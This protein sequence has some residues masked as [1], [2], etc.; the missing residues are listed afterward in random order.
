MDIEAFAIDL[1][2]FWREH[3]CMDIDGADFQ[4]MLV[5]H[6][7]VIERPATQE[8]CE[9]EWAQEY[10]TEIGDPVF[11]NSSEFIAAAKKAPTP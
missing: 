9:E 11:L 7:L 3:D 10:G 8:D 1:V 2:N 5:K 4:G 6:G